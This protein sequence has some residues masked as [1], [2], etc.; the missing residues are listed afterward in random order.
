MKG[1]TDVILGTLSIIFQV[2]GF[3][4]FPVNWKLENL[5]LVFKKGEKEDRA[6]YRPVNLTSVPGKIT[7]EVILDVT[8]YEKQLRGNAV[9]CHCQHR[10]MSFLTNLISFYDEDT[11]LAD[12]GEPVD[13]VV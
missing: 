12:Q 5:A 8:S 11:N 9:M 1:L 6:S 7:A 2:L 13:V 10:F 4:E 3:I